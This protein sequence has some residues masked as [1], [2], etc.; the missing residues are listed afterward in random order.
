MMNLK[1]HSL[2]IYFYNATSQTGPRRIGAILRYG[3]RGH[4]QGRLCDARWLLILFSRELTIVERVH[5]LLRHSG[6]TRPGIWEAFAGLRAAFFRHSSTTLTSHHIGRPLLLLP[7]SPSRHYGASPLA[8][9]IASV[10]I[11][12]HA[13]HTDSPAQCARTV[14]PNR[15]AGINRLARHRFHSHPHQRTPSPSRA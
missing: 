7:R 14:R 2:K 15:Q 9:Q 10:Q 1:T 5:S 8:G 11:I 6:L 3:Y 12:G 13:T 4:R